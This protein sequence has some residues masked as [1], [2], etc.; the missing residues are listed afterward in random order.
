MLLNINIHYKIL[1]F[2]HMCAYLSVPLLAVDG[3]LGSLGAFLPPVS[4]E[5]PQLVLALERAP[6]QA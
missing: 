2:I 5:L 6:A 3:V 4:V 1:I